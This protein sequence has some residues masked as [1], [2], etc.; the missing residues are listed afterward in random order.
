[1]HVPA[2]A[3]QELV[4]AQAEPELSPGTPERMEWLLLRNVASED[5]PAR[6]TYVCV[7]DPF[8]DNA[9]VKRVET[10]IPR[11]GK[12]ARKAGWVGLRVHHR[13]GVDTVCTALDDS[14]LIET[15]DGLRFKVRLHF[16]K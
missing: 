14:A 13:S 9:L 2:G 4:V 16:R 5:R 6:S 7:V 3:C 11:D 15:R 12:A 1:M 8:V 10:L